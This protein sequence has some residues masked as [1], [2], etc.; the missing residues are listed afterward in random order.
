MTWDA[1]CLHTFQFSSL[2]PLP[3]PANSHL[4]HP[5]IQTQAF[6]FLFPSSLFPSLSFLSRLLFPFFVFPIFLSPFRLFLCHFPSFC[7]LIQNFADRIREWGLSHYHTPCRDGPV[8]NSKNVSGSDFALFAIYFSKSLQAIEYFLWIL[9][10][11]LLFILFVIFRFE[12]S[13]P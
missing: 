11:C 5:H 4:V 6:S 10:L 7:R 2:N 13:L 9:D 1:Y 8:Y 12:I 3:F